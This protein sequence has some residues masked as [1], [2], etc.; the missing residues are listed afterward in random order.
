MQ[1]IDLPL[2]ARGLERFYRFGPITKGYDNAASVLRSESFFGTGLRPYS[3]AHLAAVQR[4]ALGATVTWQRRTRV[5]G[6]NWQSL[7]V[8]LGEDSESYV[9]RVTQGGNLRRETVVASPTWVYTTAMQASDAVSG[10]I[11]IAVAQVSQRFGNGPFRS[12]SV[13]V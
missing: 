13:T 7:E 1:Q 3:V 9:V 4:P 5:D 6:D 11:T 10:V 12:V 2:S 8:P